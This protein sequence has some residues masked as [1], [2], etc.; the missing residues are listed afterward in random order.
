VEKRGPAAL[1]RRRKRGREWSNS[2]FLLHGPHVKLCAEKKREGIKCT[3]LSSVFL[4]SPPIYI[5]IKMG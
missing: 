5:Y 3:P 4:Y 1:L 2:R